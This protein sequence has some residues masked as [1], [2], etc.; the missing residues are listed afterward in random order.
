MFVVGVLEVFEGFGV[1]LFDEFDCCWVVGFFFDIVEYIVD[2]FFWVVFG[3]G[4]FDICEEFFVVIKSLDGSWL[5][6]VDLFVLDIY[7]V[8]ICWYWLSLNFSLMVCLRFLKFYFFFFG[9][10]DG[11]L[12][13]FVMVFLG[14]FV[15]V[16]FVL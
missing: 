2:W 4:W 15:L 6:C 11:I 5:V 7:D 1:E 16:C 13:N 12:R 14:L 10:S 8:F 9:F 3:D